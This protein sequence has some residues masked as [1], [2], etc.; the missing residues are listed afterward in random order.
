[1]D[2]EALKEINNKLDLIISFLKSQK[3]ILEVPK[4]SNAN[5]KNQ[6]KGVKGGLRLLVDQGFFNVKRVF[7]EIREELKTKTYNYPRTSIQPCLIGMCKSSGPLIRTK[8]VK[9][10]YYVIRR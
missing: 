3:D 5:Q 8:E 10:Y 2:K 4:K 7:P 1:M 6:Y 9:K